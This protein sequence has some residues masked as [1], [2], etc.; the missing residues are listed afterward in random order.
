MKR[1]SAKL[2]MNLRQKRF[3]VLLPSGTLAH[4]FESMYIQ[5]N[6]EILDIN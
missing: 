3:A 4:R 5:I 6:D 2:T 1:E